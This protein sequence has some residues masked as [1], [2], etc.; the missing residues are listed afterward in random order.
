MTGLV[1][2]YYEGPPPELGARFCI[3]NFERGLH[4]L[5]FLDFAVLRFDPAKCRAAIEIASRGSR[6]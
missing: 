5:P 4:G 6:A 1:D 3:V 2:R